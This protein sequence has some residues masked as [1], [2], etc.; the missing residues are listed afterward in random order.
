MDDY[1]ER[2]RKDISKEI[3]PLQNEDHDLLVWAE[4]G[5]RDFGL[6]DIPDALM[7]ILSY[8]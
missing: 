6:E 1:V 7:A 5:V 2:S 3:A 4:R 8:L